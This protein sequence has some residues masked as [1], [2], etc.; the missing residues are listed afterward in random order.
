MAASRKLSRHGLPQMSEV[1]FIRT[2][3]AMIREIEKLRKER[4]ARGSRLSLADVARTLIWEG[5]ERAR[6]GAS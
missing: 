2:D 4:S 3:V 6:A 1:L 5:I